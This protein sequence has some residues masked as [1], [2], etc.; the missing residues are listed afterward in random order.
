MYENKQD[1]Y[2][3]I[4]NMNCFMANSFKKTYVWVYSK[5]LRYFSSWKR[6]TKFVFPSTLYLPSLLTLNAPFPL[7]LPTSLTLAEL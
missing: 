2:K 3:K 7:N 5:S 6:V 4:V 1:H